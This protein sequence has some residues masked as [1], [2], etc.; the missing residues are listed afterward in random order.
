MEEDGIYLVN[1]VDDYTH[2][3]YMPS[4]IHTLKQTFSYVYL[5]STGGSWEEVGISTFVIVATDR[6]IDLDDYKRFVT[7]NGRKNLV[8]VPYDEIKLE[9]F[10][11]ERDPILLTDDY[12]PTDILVTQLF[13]EWPS[14]R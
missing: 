10:L 6:R 3:R 1:I 11:A 2:G 13:R 12:A 4:F 5:F 9:K 8:G 7:D 14:Y